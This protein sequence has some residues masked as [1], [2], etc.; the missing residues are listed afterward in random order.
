MSKRKKILS[1][2]FALVVVLGLAGASVYANAVKMEGMAFCQEDIFLVETPSKISPQT[3]EAY[4]YFPTTMSEL[5]HGGVILSNYDGGTGSFSFEVYHGGS[6]R[7]YLVTPDNVEY[8]FIFD[9]VNLIT[10]KWTH[11]AITTADDKV[12]CYIDGTLKQTHNVKLPTGLV[13]DK[14]MAL[15][16]DVRTEANVQYFKGEI[17]SIALYSDV[18]TAA[19]I[20]EDVNSYG[21]DNLILNYSLNGVASGVAVIE[22]KT[23]NNMDAQRIARWMDSK[24]PVGDYDYSFAVMGDNQ[25]MT[26]YY[27]DKLSIMY[28]WIVDNVDDKKI[29][30]V[31]NLGDI[32][33]GN[34]D[35]EYQLARENMDKFNGVVPYSFVRGNHDFIAQYD[36]YFPYADYVD[37]VDGTFDENMRDSWKELIVGDTKYLMLMLDLGPSD[38]ELEW[39]EKII[40]EHPEHNVIICT[41]AYLNTDG[42]TLDAND[43]FNPR[44]YKEM[45]YGSDNNGDEMWDKVFKKYENIVLILSGHMGPKDGLIRTAQTEGENG[46]IVT[47]LMIDATAIETEQQGAGILAM[48]YFS[49]GGSKMTVEY[50]ST[51]RNQY[52]HPMNQFTVDL[53]LVGEDASDNGTKPDTGDVATGSIALVALASFAV[54]VI[55]L[56]KKRKEMQEE[57]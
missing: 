37:K 40:K 24:D 1:V 46:N 14:T 55:I 52:F 35:A 49:E 50:Y 16:G 3:F 32:T 10:G 25:M 33:D 7:L 27:G 30:Y 6:P 48:F 5:T 57:N 9:D 28:D 54:I 53:D 11:V 34:T 31:F 39:A 22:D 38:A 15:G 56:Q 42:T 44:S 51:V 21:T 8:D 43:A 45:S 18:R 41:H 26:R 13:Y 2:V 12:S 29:E 23:D 36:K 19:E 4:V 20:K 17:A 47:Q